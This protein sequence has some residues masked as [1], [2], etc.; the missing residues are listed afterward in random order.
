M[1]IEI[2]K[3]KLV[4]PRV[5]D[6]I[7]WKAIEADVIEE[8]VQSTRDAIREIE[9]VTLKI[10]S[11]GIL[12]DNLQHIRA[13]LHNMKGEAGFVGINVLSDVC[14]RIETELESVVHTK[15]FRADMLLDVVDWFGQVLDIARNGPLIESAELTSV[16]HASKPR[17]LIVEDGV[18]NRKLLAKM[19]REISNCDVAADGEAGLLA[20][21][22]ALDKQIPY[23]VIF[24]DI[25]MPKMDGQE[26]L[27][28]VRKEEMSRDIL[29][30]D[31]VKV[32]MTTALKDSKNVL[33]A[34]RLGCEGYLVKPIERDALFK[35]MRELKILAA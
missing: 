8:W 1:S 7:D 18:I 34:F 21:L 30:S 20:F 6:V 28:R 16:A 35:K 26:M 33:G 3:H 27:E 10:E 2:V 12:E 19:L 31:G 17:V 11:E 9:V 22:N 25:M 13:H 24:L 5:Q 29:G 23:D 32:I 4:L 15:D 14:H